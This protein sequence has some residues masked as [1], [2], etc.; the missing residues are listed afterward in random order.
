[1]NSHCDWGGNA[2]KTNYA[3]KLIKYKKVGRGN[4]LIKQFEIEELLISFKK[5]NILEN[6]N[7][8]FSIFFKL[9]GKFKY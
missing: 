1:M 7:S 5:T 6:R 2:M 4:N 9:K 8:G 3:I